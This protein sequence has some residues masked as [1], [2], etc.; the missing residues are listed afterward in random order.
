MLGM[1]RPEYIRYAQSQPLASLL[2]SLLHGGRSAR[3]LFHLRRP[4]L[5]RGAFL[6]RR[7]F[8]GRPLHT[9]AQRDVRAGILCAALRVLESVSGGGVEG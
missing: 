3:L 9:H 1:H 4:S 8:L 7:P 2:S 5:L 6:R